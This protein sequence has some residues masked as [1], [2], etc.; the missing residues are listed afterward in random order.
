MPYQAPQ[1]IETLAKFEFVLGMVPRVLLKDGVNLEGIDPQMG[2]LV[3]AALYF[4]D[5]YADE[6]FVTITSAKD[7]H[8]NVPPSFHNYGFGLDFRAPGWGSNIDQTAGRA[9][10]VEMNAAL[11]A[12]GFQ[13][14]W[15]KGPN[16]FP[17]IHGELDTPKTREIRKKV[18]E[19]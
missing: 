12:D 5:K 16:P 11:K 7:S 10:E 1:E 9:I 2:P 4:Y 13:I 8:E 18:L 6:S 19:G 3:A 15:H 17:H 14:V